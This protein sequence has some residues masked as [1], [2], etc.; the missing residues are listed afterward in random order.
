MD[1]G[2]E[3]TLEPRG[4]PVWVAI[5]LSTRLTHS[6]AESRGRV[7]AREAGA[8]QAVR[9]QAEPGNEMKKSV[10]ARRPCSPSRHLNAVPISHVDANL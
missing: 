7:G 3:R 1:A 9:S 2:L 6:P 10:P 5:R 8:S 4:M